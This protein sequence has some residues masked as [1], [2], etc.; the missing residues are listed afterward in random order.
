[1]S[2]NDPKAAWEQECYDCLEQMASEPPPPTIHQA[3]VIDEE[4]VIAGRSI[5]E[6][7]S[8]AGEIDLGCWSPRLA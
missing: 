7:F 1:M 5:E 2:Q 8:D 6:A 4:P 3:R